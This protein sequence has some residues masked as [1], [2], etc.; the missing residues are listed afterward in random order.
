MRDQQPAKGVVKEDVWINSTCNIC[1][2]M[3][4]IRVHR[5]D[6]VVVKIEG[7]PDCPTSRGGICAGGASGIMQLYDPNRVN[8]PLKRTNPEKGIGVDP[9]WVEISWEEALETIAG[10]LTKIRAEDPRKVMFILTVIPWDYTKMLFSFA[11]AFGTPNDLPSGASLHCGNG[12]HLFSG[13]AMTSWIGQPDPNY[14]NYYLNF[15]TPAGFGAYYSVSGMARR[16]ADA[17]ARGM[18]NVV[19]EPYM[20]MPGSKSDEWVPIRPGTDAALALAMANLL[21]NEYGIYDKQYLK[22]YT[23]GPYLVGADGFY[24]RDKETNKPLLWDLTDGKAKTYDD[25]SLKEITLEGSFSVNGAVV[26]T[27][28]ATLK[29]HVKKYTPEM[30]SEITTVPARTIRRLAKEFG[31]AARIGSTIQIDGKE[32]PYRPVAV[33]YFRGAAAHKHCAL[34]CMAIGLLQEIVGATNVPGG[35]LGANG[36]FF[37]HPDTEYGSYTPYEGLDGL[38]EGGAQPIGHGFWPLP[39]PKKPE[40]VGMNDL[41]PTSTVSPL[42]LMGMTEREKYK[43]PYEIEFIWH[44]GGNY[45]MSLY[46]IRRLEE[47]FKKKNIF[48]ASVSIYLDESTDFSDIVLPD[49]G[50]LERLD[51]TADWESS[52]SPVDEWAL[53]LRQPVVEPMFQRRPFQKIMLDVMERIGLLPDMYALM[54]MIYNMKEPYALDPTK[55][56]AWEEIV[57]RRLR[58]HFGNERGL[59]WF[60]ENG[61]VRW[62]KKVEEVYWRPFVKG[63]TPIYFEY[64]KTLGEKIDKIKKEYDIPDFDTSD[65]QMLPE[66][67][68]CASYEERRPGFDLYGIYYRVS[69]H[70]STWT[71]NNPWLNEVSTMDPYL[72]YVEMNA[73]TAKKKGIK[74]GDL[75]VVES[76]ATGNKVEGRVAVTEGIHPEVIAYAS[77]GGHWSKR[78][79]IATGPGKGIAPNW[80]I[81]LDWDH[82][83]TVTLNL[84]LC[85]K[86]KVTKTQKELEL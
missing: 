6:G 48:T 64:F 24:V 56:Y 58:C 77:G 72:Y 1:F 65:F 73:E 86:V 22:T 17:R 71:Y 4:A 76:A 5:V 32:L 62:P 21:I 13:L 79:P 11:Y 18:K 55:K 51:L 34:N 12:A 37:G 82:I 74:S 2:S 63:R 3:C 43:I 83:D 14:V 66:W 31:E 85:V 36:R 10:R 7:N 80:L 8:V 23:N 78:L 16:M 70:S 68:P 26:T 39:E 84:D 29:E 38:L 59:D 67:K 75:V 45:M 49:C 40:K 57:D 33:G 47:F 52:I 20:G 50:Y 54:N 69:F 61:L 44:V 81:P 19:I 35:T 60:K 42:F 25:P 30:A 28:F 53:H 46:D 9:K 15:G 41:I 27:A